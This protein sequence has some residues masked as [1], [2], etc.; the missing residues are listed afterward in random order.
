[1]TGTVAYILAKKFATG[2]ASGIS[3]V[4]LQGTNIVFHFNDG[5]QG[6][7]A[8]PTPE[9]G[10]DGLSVVSIEIDKDS[11]L[12]CVLSDGT[13]LDA[14]MIPHGQGGGLQAAASLAKFP[15]PGDENTLYLALDTGILYYWNVK[16]NKYNPIAG[17]SSPIDDASLAKKED[18][19]KLFDNMGPDISLATRTDIDNLFA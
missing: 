5:T 3:S 12:I 1:M 16:S 2:V 14:G 13:K 19:D 10:K 17:N 11:H 15:V 6:V 4:E 9:N 18:I 8:I 7:V